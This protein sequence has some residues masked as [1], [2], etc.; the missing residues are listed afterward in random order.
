MRDRDK[1]KAQLIDELRQLSRRLAD[2]E[3]VDRQG[4]RTEVP[5]HR[6]SKALEMLISG[7][8]VVMGATDESD[9]IRET[10]RIVVEIGGYRLAWV[11]FAEGEKKTT[12]RPVGQWGHEDGYLATADIP[13]ANTPRGRDPT[14]TAIRTRKPSIVRHILT[15]RDDEPWRAEARKRGYGSSIA[16][17]LL[18]GG[19][20]FGALHIYAAEDDAFDRLEVRLLTELAECLS[21][22]LRMLRLRGEHERTEE[23]LSKSETKCSTVVESSLTGIYVEQDGKIVFANDQFAQ[24]H[25]Y[26]KDEL[27]GMDA[28]AFIHPKDRPL[29]D[30]ISARR[31]KGEKAPAE[32]VVRGLTRDGK[33]IWAMRRNTLIDV[34]GDSAILGNVVDITRRKEIEKTLKKSQRDLRL[35]SS[36]L[37]TAQEDER[38]RIAR[39]LHDSIGQSLSAIKFGLENALRRVENRAFE[40][41]I[42]SL[43]GLIPL[44]QT[45]IEEVRKIG[46]DLRPSTLDDLGILATITWFCREF[47]LIYSGIQ[48]EKRMEVE[49]EDVPYSLRTT[50]YRVLQ[51]ALN[52]VA[53]H[54]QA[55]L[56]SVVLRKTNNGLEL[57]VQD[58]GV[59]FDEGSV[60]RAA[61][62]KQGLGLASMRERVE[63]S[64]GSFSIES[65]PGQGT[66]VR[67]C[68][69]DERMSTN[70]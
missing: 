37:L 21:Y 10:C 4:K 1:T 39:E 60:P 18:D 22:G 23:E 51:E 52:N 53:K 66:V 47:E 41:C 3:R 58:N 45:A 24:I 19:S 16:L 6:V 27:S 49:E 67:A 42:E 11:G 48:I 33:T 55:N 68:W 34:G 7:R 30:Q 62:T 15:K 13:W 57:A 38:K 20:A 36:Q 50:I 44:I 70:A 9:L 56:G 31:L 29:I 65:G 61:A 2:A 14:G 63:L 54:S 35:L 5:L 32:Y 12:V 28:L 64:G 25:G 46:M 43:K 69:A 40:A 17:P 8:Q 59:G 26:S